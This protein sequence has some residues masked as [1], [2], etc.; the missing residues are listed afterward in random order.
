LAIL[1][2]D[3]DRKTVDLVRLYLERAGFAVRVGYD[4]RQA[5]RLAREERPDLVILDLML[6]HIDGLDVCHVLRQEIGTLP[7]IML[8]ARSTE[9]DKL[10]G[11]ETG[12]DDYVTKPFSPAELVARVRAVLRRAEPPAQEAETRIGE[13]VVDNVRREAW[14]AGARVRLTPREFRLLQALA[15]DADRP[16]SRDD[17][18][19]RAFGFEYEGLERTVDAHVA[20]LRKKI[21]PNPSRPI[22]VLTVPGVGYKLAREP[23]RSA[24]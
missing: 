15:R 24:D 13:L 10:G 8:S 19:E 22:Y 14:V 9:A 16:L 18:V 12:A 17:L 5:L 21:E 20:N 1:V 2:V 4:G 23:L 6:P 11:L 3:D 7:V